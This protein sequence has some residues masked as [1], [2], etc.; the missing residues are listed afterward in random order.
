MKIILSI[1]LKELKLLFKDPAGLIM[2]FILPAIFIFVLS[3]ALQGAFSSVDST[4][5]MDILVINDD[6]GITGK[7]IIKG[8][9]DTGYFNP[10]D[11]VENKKLDLATAKEKL[12]TGKYKIAIYLPE[13][14]TEAVNFKRETQIDIYVDPVLSSEFV[15]NITNIIQNYVNVAL[16]RNIAQ[17]STNIFN[18][19]SANRLS[20]INNH[21]VTAS[22]KRD[23]LNN[24]LQEV[25]ASE[26]DE[27]NKALIIQLTTD[28]IKELNSNIEE[29]EEQKRG[30]SKSASTN[31]DLIKNKYNIEDTNVGLKVNQIY[32]SSSVDEVL[33]TSV[34]QNVPGWTIF[35]L[36]WIV[37]LLA[38][39]I[40]MER[41]SG[42][43]K[44]ILIA[45]I[46]MS[47]YIIGK[48]IPFFVINLLQAVCMFLIGIF[49]LPLFGCPKLIISNVFTLFI[50][51]VVISIT[52]ISLGLFISSIAK[53]I[54]FA[55]SISALL[56]IISAVL[57][58]IMVP[59]FVMPSIM[60]KLSYF[61][62]QGW[63]LEG[64]LN[65]IIKNHTIIQVLPHIIAL[66]VF[67]TIFF[68]FSFF[69]F[70]KLST[71][72]NE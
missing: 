48:I 44:R 40:I 27:D 10:I 68:A 55:A 62:P 35:A 39:N 56:L 1:S 14:A 33:P 4:E 8:L 28:S 60:Q 41:Q 36:F 71:N 46:R 37:Q 6:I 66:L 23:E 49:V 18:D 15:A 58:G 17:I 47:D 64:Y 16:I 29:L 5:K 31:E 53:S 57:A 72:F 38:M 22:Q 7:E 11:T 43:F 12:N 24:Q 34:Q 69:R 30:Y 59:K 9:A 26:M 32:Y 2:L 25:A 54:F 45:P 67:S 63:A 61:V 19:I 13:Y 3:I 65:I 51:T 21:I 70:W 20:E 42:V 52:A 50:M